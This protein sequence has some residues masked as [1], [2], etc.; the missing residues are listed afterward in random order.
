V[1]ALANGLEDFDV[2]RRCTAVVAVILVLGVADNS[3]AAPQG[4]EGHGR[5]VGNAGNDCAGIV[6]ENGRI[7]VDGV[8]VEDGRVLQ[9]GQ[10]GRGEVATERVFIGT[11]CARGLIVI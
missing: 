11:M 2:D 4:S 9:R 6:G 3:L 5:V 1:H 10:D 8:G 7:H